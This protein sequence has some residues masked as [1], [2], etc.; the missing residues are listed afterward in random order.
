M[1]LDGTQ[2]GSDLD[3]VFSTVCPP[4]SVTLSAL[5]VCVVGGLIIAVVV[6]LA[7]VVLLRRKRITRRRT[8]RRL[9]QERE[10]DASLKTT[11]SQN[12]GHILE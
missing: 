6:S 9:R 2:K 10:V 5:A 1:T 3:I 7:V 11:T 8:L 12:W 4:S